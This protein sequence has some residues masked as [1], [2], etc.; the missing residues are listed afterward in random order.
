MARKRRDRNEQPAPES[1]KQQ[2]LSRRDRE[3]RKLILSIA[4]PLLVLAG[5]I[6]VF[7]AWRELYQIPNTPVAEVDGE[8]V[9]ASAFTQRIDYDR[10]LL[11]NRIRS[12]MPLLQSNDPSVI[13]QLVGGQRTN[14]AQTT[15]D[16]L[17]D[18]AIIRQESAKRGLPVAEA[19]VDQQI[20]GEIA[21]AL[22]PP[23]TSAPEVTP[24]PAITGTAAAA[25]TLGTVV[26]TAT[27]A[28]TA[29]PAPTLAVTPISTQ[30]VGRQ[31]EQMVQPMLDQLKM[32]QSQYRNIVRQQVYRDKLKKVLSDAIPT[33]EKQVELEY[34]QFKDKETADKAAAEL[35]KGTSWD[36]VL[37]QYGPTPTP[38]PGASPTP[39]EPPSAPTPAAGTPGGATATAGPPPTATPEPYAQQKGGPTWFT[40]HKLTT[41]WA[42]KAEDVDTL[43][44][45]AKGKASQAIA[46]GSGFYVAFVRDVDEQ[47]AVDEAELKTRRDNALDDWLKPRKDELDKAG[48]IKKY[49]LEAFVPPEPAWFSEGFDRLLATPAATLPGGGLSVLTVVPPAES[50][51]PA[52][53]PASGGTPAP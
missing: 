51:S 21:T 44:A 50:T 48:K 16:N 3:Q 27:P 26:A 20:Y 52:G 30:E 39:T 31:F 37:A 11:L 41:D 2:H 42:A 34:L 18:E 47:R 33:A 35:A 14:I 45:V 23:A 22:A 1:R 19:D 43:M 40:K 28:G 17:I 36:K 4:V 46:G 8:R 38:A 15:Q 7:G 13:S 25:A 53:T 32:T 6:L 49:P 5:G 12:F 9:P 24:T 29:T 10:R